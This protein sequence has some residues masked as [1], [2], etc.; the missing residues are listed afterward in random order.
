MFIL[1][2]YCIA[3]CFRHVFTGK[4]FSFLMHQLILWFQFLLCPANVVEENKILKS[5]NRIFHRSSQS[6]HG[7]LISSTLGIGQFLHQFFQCSDV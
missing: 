3:I 1:N 7:L 2:F 5:L 4:L 6:L